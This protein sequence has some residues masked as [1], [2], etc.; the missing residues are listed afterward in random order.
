MQ[1]RSRLLS[2]TGFF[3]L[4]FILSVFLTIRIHRD[5][6]VF[7]WKSEIWVDKAGYYI[8]LPA[9]FMYRFD[10]D[11]FPEKIDDKTGDG[12]LLDYRN[13]K[14]NDKYSCGVAILLSPFFVA[15]HY[16]S[17]LFHIPEE[18]G[19][20]PAYHR[21]TDIAGVVYLILG[22]WLLKQFLG[23]SFSPGISFLAVFFLYAGTN[24]FYYGLDDSLMSHVYSFFLF[25]LFLFSLQNFLEHNRIR[26]FLLLSVAFSLA[27]LIR[28]TSAILILLPLFW[29]VASFREMKTRMKMLIR[30]GYILT[31][32]IVL[33]IVFLPQMLYWKYLTGHFLYYSYGPEGF[34]NW[35][36]PF[37]AQVWFSPVNGLFIYTPAM[38]LFLAGMI[39]MLIKKMKNGWLITAFFFLVSYLFASWFTWYF[40]C[41]YGQ[42]SFVEY[43]SLFSVPFGV[44]LERTFRPGNRFVKSTVFLLVLAFSYYNVRLSLNYEKCF[45]G[46]T[47]DWNRYAGLL[48]KAGLAERPDKNYRF[49]NDFEN[50]ALAN[51][52]QVTETVSRSGRTSVV[53]TPD[54]EYGCRFLESLSALGDHTPSFIRTEIWIMKTSGDST[55]A[56]LVCS[57]E[58]KGRSLIWQS[59]QVDRYVMA[60]NRWYR[61]ARTFVIPDTTGRWADLSVY[62]WNRKHAFFYADDM[63]VECRDIYQ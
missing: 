24:L 55:G 33:V 51:L 14:L 4:L 53:M 46:S 60:A 22:L 31:F 35:R 40:A 20:S 38:L 18:G 25:A 16:Y 1:R 23:R 13:R 36:T 62:L 6:G 32:L 49:Y 30:P 28:P 3:V 34:T 44:V 59:E 52:N 15:T 50:T 12:F 39:I 10:F 37:L 2:E 9:T 26:F 11:R 63:T 47:W 19:F 54:K 27:V 56:L 43:F 41:S 21:M 45:F 61:V 48:E 58:R 5:R 42:R 8:Y 7:N 17:K 29:N 57:V